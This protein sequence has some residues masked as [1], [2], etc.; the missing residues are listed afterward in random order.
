MQLYFSK[1]GKP[2]PTMQGNAGNPPLAEMDD[3]YDVPYEEQMAAARAKVK[4]ESDHQY[5]NGTVQTS[6]R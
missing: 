3:L 1:Q 5:V 6:K 4:A 2:T